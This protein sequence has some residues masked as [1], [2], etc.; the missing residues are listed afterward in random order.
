MFKFKRLER[1][2]LLRF[3]EQEK[4]AALNRV[5]EIIYVHLCLREE[6]LC[7]NDNYITEELQIS[8]IY[9]YN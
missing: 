4:L 1:Q 7:F 3:C 5:A 2:K 9:I 6:K 8:I